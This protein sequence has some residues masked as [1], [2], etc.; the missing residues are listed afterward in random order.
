MPFYQRLAALE[1]LQVVVTAPKR[2]TEIAAYLDSYGFKPDDIVFLDDQQP[3][4]AIRVTP[5]LLI[6][7]SDGLVTHSW[8]GV[9]SE[10]A[11]VEVLRVLGV[12]A[13]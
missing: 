11:E 13:A 4:L 5:T 3:R 8:M 7:D 1:D 6:V 10:D 2:D 9:L 12:E